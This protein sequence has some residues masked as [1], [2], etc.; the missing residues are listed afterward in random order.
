MNLSRVLHP[1]D[2]KLFTEHL[3]VELVMSKLTDYRYEHEHRKWEYGLAL[4]AVLD[5][6]SKTVLDVGGAGAIL[7]PLFAYYDCDVTQLDPEFGRELVISQNKILG[8]DIKFISGDFSTVEL[9][10]FDAVVSIS[11]IEH[12]HDDGAF[13]IDLLKHANKV[14]FITM[15]FFPTCEKFSKDHIRTYNKE[16]V[17]EFCEIAKEFDFIS[18]PS[19]YDYRGNF[20][21]NYTFASLFLTKDSK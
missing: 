8:T 17:Y 2:Y 12:V 19:L 11:T 16:R 6:E 21:Y 18:T 1:N 4:K 20:V 10:K 15:D 7:S 3:A 13:F 9:G 14:V 5:T